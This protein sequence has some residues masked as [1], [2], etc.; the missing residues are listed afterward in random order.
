MMAAENKSTL[1]QKCD[2]I[3]HFEASDSLLFKEISKYL[4]PNPRKIKRI[5]NIYRAVRLI[6]ALS[7]RISSIANIKLLKWVILIEQWP[8]RMAWL[9][10]A[11]EDEEQ[12]LQLNQKSNLRSRLLKDFYKD[13]V[14]MRIYNSYCRKDCPE[15]L[16]N[17]YNKIYLLDSDPEI[18][19]ALLESS[20]IRIQDLGNSSSRSASK[21]LTY[22]IGLNPSIR[23]IISSIAAYRYDDENLREAIKPRYLLT[24][25]KI[26]DVSEKSGYAKKSRNSMS[27][28]YVKFSD[29][30]SRSRS[31]SLSGSSELLSPLNEND[32]ESV[33][34][35]EAESPS[36]A[37][38][39][40]AF[41][42]DPQGSQEAAWTEATSG[43]SPRAPSEDEGQPTDSVSFL[44]CALVFSALVRH[45]LTAPVII[46]LYSAVGKSYFTELIFGSLKAIWLHEKIQ[47]YM[48]IEDQQ[49]SYQTSS[50]Q[51]HE[52][53]EQKS[54]ESTSS[55][56]TKL[57]NERTTGSLP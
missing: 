53:V 33:L 24:V 46:G 9:I 2:E 42:V 3:V 31:R 51:A 1:L 36:H 23:N 15:S 30:V 27:N 34:G 45:G 8:V 52:T 32:I 17:R 41:V 19:E 56:A 21:L 49:N 37:A 43:S 5:T 13:Y 57:L 20:E 26:D 39:G 14:E 29:Q 12:K 11:L 47:L 10:Q 48:S 4:V 55:E 38:T 35:S 25:E 50:E 7:K 40:A 6:S 44:H 28:A 18:F 54:D 16:V 22:S